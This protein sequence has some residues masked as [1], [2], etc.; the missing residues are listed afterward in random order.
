MAHHILYG[1]LVFKKWILTLE[2]KNTQKRG[3]GICDCFFLGGRGASSGSTSR[4]SRSS[5]DNLTKNTLNMTAKDYQASHSHI[6]CSSV[7]N[8]SSV[9]L[10]TLWL[11]CQHFP[12]GK[13]TS[14]FPYEGNLWRIRS[15]HF[16]WLHFKHNSSNTENPAL[17]RYRVN[18]DVVY[19]L[20]QWY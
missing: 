18:I 1:L 5:S 16:H 10:N 12:V 2:L 6:P 19:S 17:S 3:E 11:D 9:F 7:C 15:V 8:H 20:K 13:K 14:I 4:M